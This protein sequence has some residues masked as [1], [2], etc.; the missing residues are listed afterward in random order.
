MLVVS[1]A[2]PINILVRI[3]H[4]DILPRLFDRVLIPGTVAKELSHKRT[5]PEVLAWIQSG[6]A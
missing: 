3:G 1:D 6:P 5:P 2:S 4:I